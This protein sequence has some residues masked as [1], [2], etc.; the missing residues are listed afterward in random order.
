MDSKNENRTS[1]LLTFDNEMI[2]FLRTQTNNKFSRFDAFIWLM[3]F[4]KNSH[5]DFDLVGAYP[6]LTQ[7]A[8][9]NTELAEFWHWSR[10]TVQKFMQELVNKNIIAKRR[11]GSAYQLSLTA[12]AAERLKL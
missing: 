9:N 8:T 4:I 2:K 1:R 7:G 11:H 12:E 6:E 3:D 10:P 5:P